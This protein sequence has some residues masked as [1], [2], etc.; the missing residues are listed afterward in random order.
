M[1]ECNRCKQSLPLDAFHKSKANKDGFN[2]RCGKCT[3]S[4]NKEHYKET[5]EKR[6][7]YQREWDR[8][9]KF[10]SRF[11]KY[12]ITLDD[13]NQM[14]AAQNNMCAVCKRVPEGYFYIDHCHKTKTVR[15][16]LCLRCNT[17]LGNFRDD[18]SILQSAISYLTDNK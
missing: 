5:R 1:K 6:L 4:Y 7:A 15:G 17:G 16:L 13:Y 3:A 9:N 18:P 12:G 11:S 2:R 10:R 14:L 8:K